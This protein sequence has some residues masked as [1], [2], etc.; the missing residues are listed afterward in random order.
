MFI[1][2]WETG[3]QSWRPGAFQEDHKDNCRTCG[4]PILFLAVESTFTSKRKQEGLWYHEDI[5]MY[6]ED[7]GPEGYRIQLTRREKDRRQHGHIPEPR[8]FCIEYTTDGTTYEI[9]GRPIK[10]ED[11]KA[12][13]LAC[14]IHMKALLSRKAQMER[15]RKHR[16]ERTRREELEAFQKEQYSAAAQRLRDAGYG[17]I[18]EDWRVDRWHFRKEVSVDLFRLAEILAPEEVDEYVE[19][20]SGDGDPSIFDS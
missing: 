8:S 19:V 9:C 15:D 1:S 14:G 13:N 4:Q 20:A 2:Q 12:D 18:V 10:Y 5:D 16:E 11:I 7:D 6:L 3:V 17:D